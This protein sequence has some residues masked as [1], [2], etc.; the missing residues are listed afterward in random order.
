MQAGHHLLDDRRVLAGEAALDAPYCE[1]PERVE[2]RCRAAVGH[3][4]ASRT[5][6]SPSG[7]ARSSGAGR[8]GAAPAGASA[9]RMLRQARTAPGF[10]RAAPDRATAAPPRTRPCRPSA[11]RGS[12]P[13][14]PRVRPFRACRLAPRRARTCSTSRVYVRCVGGVLVG[15][16]AR[17]R[18]YAAGARR[19][20]RRAGGLRAPGSTGR[21]RRCLRRPQRERAQVLLHRDAVQPDGVLERSRWQRDPACLVGGSEQ[22]HVRVL[23]ARGIPPVH[24]ARVSIR[25]PVARPADRVDSAMSARRD[26]GKPASASTIICPVGTSTQS[27]RRR[28]CGPGSATPRCFGSAATSMSQP[29]YRSHSAGAEL[30]R[31]RQ[32]AP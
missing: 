24:S 13:R 27:R 8:A 1:S 31:S 22:Q 7:P 12:A 9:T 2:R 21:G 4:A 28:R 18:D 16:E 32:Q 15:D 10:A 20:R 30:V 19:A 17:N 14:S 11:C 3:R 5:A 25:A 29:R 23:I 26:P 6:A